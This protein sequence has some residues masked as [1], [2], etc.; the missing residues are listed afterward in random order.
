MKKRDIKL[1]LL[2]LLLALVGIVVFL[3]YTSDSNVTGNVIL[4]TS[5]NVTI[6]KS[7]NSY[8]C[9]DSTVIYLPFDSDFN[10]KSA[11][12]INSTANQVS[13]V[14][15]KF[16]NSSFFSNVSRMEMPLLLSSD[17]LF[18][19]LWIKASNTSS[20]VF[21]IGN[22][23]L[24][25]LSLSYRNGLVLY[26]LK[27]IIAFKT[28]TGEWHHVQIAFSSKEIKVYLDDD[29]IGM[30]AARGDKINS[31]KLIFSNFS[32]FIDDFFISTTEKAI[33]DTACIS[34]PGCLDSDNGI[35]I[36]EK[37]ITITKSERSEDFCLIEDNSLK[38]V[39][40]YYCLN[41]AIAYKIMDC[42]NGCFDG[43]C[44]A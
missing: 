26:Y 18:I 32:G 25:F 36:N 44:V 42:P 19:S 10:D 1:I 11:R 37:G 24:S 14:P 22:K 5:G 30:S 6:E 9:D 29:L 3:A 41:D 28:V 16:S 8:I 12:A 43:A 20:N 13:L 31:D 2:V 7:P 39:N 23:N 33:N 40:E 15:G 38:Y 17:Q 21:D 34:L 4:E 27:D 35:N